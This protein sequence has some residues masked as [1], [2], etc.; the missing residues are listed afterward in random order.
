GGWGLG[1]SLVRQIALRHGGRAWCEAPPEGGT[2]FAVELPA[3]P[4]AEATRA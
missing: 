1:L 4:Q 3:A 2:L